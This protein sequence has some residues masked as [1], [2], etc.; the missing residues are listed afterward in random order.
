MVRAFITFSMDK[1]II[2]HILFIFMLILSI[3]AYQNIPKEIFPPSNMDEISITGAYMGASADVLDKMVV[4]SIEDELKGISEID[5]VETTIQNGYFYIKS[6]IKTGNDNQLVLGDIK[7]I[8]SNIKRDLPADMNEPTAKIVVHDF[9]LLLVAISGDVDKKRLI[10]VAEDFKSQ[11]SVLNNLSSIVIQGDADDEILISV[12]D[13]KLEAYGL[14]KA[15][16]FRAISSLSTIFPIGTIEQ[17]GEHLFLSTINGEKSAKALGDTIL[18]ISN[19]KIHLKDIALV[20]F[21]LGDSNQI[22]HYNGKQNI[23][24]NISKTKDGNAI[25]LSRQIKNMVK[26]LTTKY[27]D[28]EIKIYTDTSIW[29][30]NRLNLVSSNILFGLILV[31]ISLLLS[32]N[33]RIAIVVALGIPTSFMITIIMADM[34]GYSLNMLTL[35]GALIALGMIVDEA[36][37]VAEN[38]HRHFEMGK[39]PR[40]ASIDGAV[41]MFPAVLTATLTTVFAFLPLLIM[42]GEMGM[43]MKVLPVMISIL[44]LSSLFEAFFFLPLHSKELYTINAKEH[45]KE[46]TPFWNIN[47]K[48][49]KAIISFLFNHKIKSLILMVA[50]IIASTIAMLKITKFQL[51]P[52]FDTTQ[53]YIS[54]KININ[55]KLE[56]TETKVTEIEK[57]LVKR[58]GEKE[59]SSVT[60]VIG[61]KMNPDQ[62]FET[63]DNLFQ[64][65][66]NLHEKAPENIF[67]KY[68]NPYLSLEYDGE[69][70]IRVK[71]AQEI[72]K[73]LNKEL[74]QD[75]KVKKN[76]KGELVFNEI[77]VF[78]PQ[79]G[80][81]S[82]DID[83]GFS[84]TNITK[85]LNAMDILK[86][87]LS[88]ID[89]VNDV[90]DNAK[91]GTKE[92]KFRVNEYGQDLGFSEAYITSI[93]KGVFL[94][95]E[96]G[97]S[98]D[99]TG[100]IRIKIEDINKDSKD[101]LNSIKL[102]TPNQQNIVRLKDIC[103]FYYKQSFVKIFK[104]DSKRVRSVFAR[105]D[106]KKIIASEVMSQIQPIL[107][108]ISKTGVEVIIKGEARENAK[109]KKEMSQASLI[110]IF[111]IF[112][113]LVWMFNSMLLPLLVISSIPLSIVGA[114][115]GAKI[116]GINLTMPGV[117][118]IIGLAGVVVNDGLIMISFIKK[119]KNLNEVVEYSATRLRPILLTSITTIL[120]LFTLM[121]FASGQALIIQPMAVSLG[122]GIAW[123]TV[124]N[125]Y[126]IPL[127]YT[128]IYRVKKIKE[129]D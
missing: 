60:S 113:S 24:I 55:N 38:I 102:I 5:S 35:L 4:K 23:S 89:G 94:K 69:D 29:I 64:I 103:D 73:S 85:L 14:S 108:E 121:F 106:T 128:V 109:L 54:G 116:V 98:F 30:K 112:I 100:L 3:F 50:I 83:I 9:P 22:S 101:I 75:A 117:M 57:E 78:V 61:L 105:V 56:D 28:V 104:E 26:K 45:H 44:L 49:Y 15:D 27:D 34:I 31:F 127:L 119:A 111:L 71:K 74:I 48:I 20:E 93:L 82:Y 47:I 40:D 2:N 63:G 16:T 92:I 90:S 124:L 120:G 6:A 12:D 39:S 107:D 25:A 21:K 86:N 115:I 97:K 33:L 72:A 87:R 65:F 129:Y 99:D 114:L 11:L 95:S 46:L 96:Y 68:I 19:K 84:D 37:V 77:N 70:M 42:S 80:I 110:A 7:D 79:T 8:I 51:F 123:A 18:T 32:V 1:P 59:I 66:V 91:E 10:E 58:L 88:S 76:N 126:Y 81:T 53:I 43:F 41:E 122:F 17:Q 13:K 67:D 52:E 125:L 62:T 36:I 118:G